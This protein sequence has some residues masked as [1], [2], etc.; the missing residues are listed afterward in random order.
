MSR[1]KR[2]FLSKETTKQMR[3]H[4]EGQCEIEDPDIMSHLADSEA[5][6]ALDRFDPKFIGDPRSVHL[7]LSMDGFQPHNIDSHLYKGLRD[8]IQSSS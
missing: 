3:W 2:L 4:N 6:Q 5:W 8:T 1:L 7:G